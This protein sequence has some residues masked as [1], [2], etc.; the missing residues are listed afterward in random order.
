MLKKHSFLVPVLSG[1]I[2]HL[3]PVEMMLAIDTPSCRYFLL[4][5]VC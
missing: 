2:N 1:E 3:L 4:L 5:L